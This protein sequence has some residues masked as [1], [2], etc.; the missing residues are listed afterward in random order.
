MLCA[1]GA[2]AHDVSLDVTGS[3]I[4]QSQNNPRTGSFGAAGSGSIDFNDSW[5]AWAGLTFTRDLGTKTAAQSSPGSNIFLI[6]AGGLF[7]PNDHLMF[8]VAGNFAPPSRQA[9]S[10]TNT[11]ELPTR[12]ETVSVTVNS[13]TT[14]GGMSLMGSWMSNGFGELNHTVDLLV[15]VT[16]FNSDQ[17]I[18]VPDTFAG[19]VW[20]AHCSQPKYS[21]SNY[22]P[23]VNGV[24]STL[25]QARLGATYTLTIGRRFDL[26]LDGAFYVYS[27]DPTALGYFSVVEFGRLPELGSGVPVAPYLF[28]GKVFSQYR[29][30]KFAFKLS[31]QYGHSVGGYGANHFVSLRTSYKVRPGLKL[32]L[33]LSGQADASANGLLNFGVQ[34]T[35]GGLYSF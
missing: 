6:N 17:K 9:H 16:A 27:E 8:M 18:E 20:R 10:T 14:S 21:G 12:T 28:S 24:T 5:S 35:L 25:V 11:F 13:L 30:E 22:C 4:S 33:T 15:G 3:T 23:L 7:I 31:Y 19:A 2:A 34:G 32:T 29:F 26:G 1:S